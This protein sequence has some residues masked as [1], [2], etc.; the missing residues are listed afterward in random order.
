MELLVRVQC[1][2]TKMM[3]GMEYLSHDERLKELGLFF[4]EK[5][6]FGG[7]SVNI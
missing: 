3:K 5:R 7:I 4:L 1:R 2:A 6:R